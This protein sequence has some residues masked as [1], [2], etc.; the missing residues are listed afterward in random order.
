LSGP[1]VRRAQR[2]IVAGMMVLGCAVPV[3]ARP[4]RAQV[5]VS[6]LPQGFVAER[7]GGDLIDVHVLVGPGFSPAT[8]DPSP[9][10]M[11]HLHQAELL[12]R[13]GVPFEDRLLPR[14]QSTMAELLVVDG[15]SGIDLVAG[16]GHHG[17]S[18]GGKDPHFWLDPSLMKIHARTIC[19]A[20]CDL[21]PAGCSVFKSNTTALEHDL[22][23]VDRRLAELLA[24]HAGKKVFAFHPAYGYLAR[25]Y[26]LQTVAAETEGKEPGPRHLTLLIE[27]AREAGVR[28]IFAQP[29]FTARTADALAESIGGT[30]V[31]LDPLAAAYLE[32]L[33]HMGQAI[34]TALAGVAR[35]ESE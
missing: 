7:I 22:D 16:D 11:A 30:V 32:N 21:E 25:R 10:Q 34:N 6:I 27:E 4:D 12:I 23:V 35:E 5:W 31:T 2:L 1:R 29:Q 13:I 20:L 8:F 14:L 19:S 18:H 24:P 15:R 26:K 28:T 17:H 3:S 9:H 33:L